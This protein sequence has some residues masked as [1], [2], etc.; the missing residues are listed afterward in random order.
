[1]LQYNEY[2]KRIKKVNSNGPKEDVSVCER[3]IVM[4]LGK[5]KA[6]VVKQRLDIY[7]FLRDHDL[8]NEKIISKENFV[9]G[10]A[11]AGISLTETELEVL[12]NV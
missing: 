12:M 3:D 5:I 7:P 6:K 4:I 2:V 1:M 9:R 10:I 11:T 8:C